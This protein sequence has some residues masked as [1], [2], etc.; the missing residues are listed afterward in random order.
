MAKCE[1]QIRRV[2][3]EWICSLSFDPVLLAEDLYSD[4]SDYSSKRW[5]KGVA[6]EEYTGLLR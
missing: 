1:N 6:R 2:A 5:V 3:V 4:V